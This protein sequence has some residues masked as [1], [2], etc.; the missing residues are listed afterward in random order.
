M[1][2]NQLSKPG[3]PI[4]KWYDWVAASVPPGP[5]ALID[6]EYDVCKDLDIDSDGL[7]SYSPLLPPLPDAERFRVK[8]PD[9]TEPTVIEA[10]VNA[11]LKPQSFINRPG[12]EQ[13]TKWLISSFPPLSFPPWINNYSVS[14]LQGGLVLPRLKPD[15]LFELAK[16]GMNVNHLAHGAPTLIA[17]NATGYANR[18]EIWLLAFSDKKHYDSITSVLTNKVYGGDP[19]KVRGFYNYLNPLGN[20]HWREYYW[21]DNYKRLSEIKLVYD[22]TNGFGNPAQVGPAIPSK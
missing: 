21:G 1:L 15:V 9:C 5:A 3:Q 10:I 20:P 22:K 17:P 7:C 18:E 16:L 13:I 11:A 14:T 4:S 8:V 6:D 2:C 19:A 12:T